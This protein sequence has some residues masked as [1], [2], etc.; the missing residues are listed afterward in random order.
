MLHFAF[1]IFPKQIARM[2]S[3]DHT[4]TACILKTIFFSIRPFALRLQLFY[5]EV[6]VVNPLGSKTRK[7]LILCLLF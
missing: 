1:L 2:A 7:K 4:A 5:D 6:E 3:L